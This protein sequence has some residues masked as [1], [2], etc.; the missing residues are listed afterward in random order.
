M[1]VDPGGDYKL[2]RA[3]SA[4]VHALKAQTQFTSCRFLLF[5]SLARILYFARLAPLLAVSRVVKS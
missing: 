2:N 5:W 3:R 1:I 4:K